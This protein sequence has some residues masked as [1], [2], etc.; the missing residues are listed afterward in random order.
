MPQSTKD[1][2]GGKSHP[3][4]SEGS[5]GGGAKPEKKSLNDSPTGSQKRDEKKTTP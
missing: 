5:K 4:K 3:S 2:A 1:S